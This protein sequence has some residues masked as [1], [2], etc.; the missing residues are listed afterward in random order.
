MKSLDYFLRRGRNKW[1]G[2]E[3]YKILIW[4]YLGKIP[5][6]PRRAP[7]ADVVSVSKLFEV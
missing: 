1:G 6:N 3:E 4:G 5:Y 2:N 7:G